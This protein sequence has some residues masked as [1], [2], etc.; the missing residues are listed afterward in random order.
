M[1]KG[2]NG[3]CAHRDLC[4]RESMR[5]RPLWL[6]LS[7]N[8]SDYLCFIMRNLFVIL[9]FV[10]L[11]ASCG[12]S[13]STDADTVNHGPGVPDP[14]AIVPAKAVDANA[15]DSVFANDF[16]QLISCGLLEDFDVLYLVPNLIP[17]VQ[18]DAMASG[19]DTI[20][21]QM[22]IDRVR[23][24]KLSGDYAVIKNRMHQVD[25]LRTL[26][27]NLVNWNADTAMLSKLGMTPGE[28][29]M[30]RKT[31]EE[32]LKKNPNL[33]WDALLDS[34]DARLQRTDP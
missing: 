1:H 24:F 25:S 15:P 32:L 12:D 27:V 4:V 23:R 29:Q 34:T 26:P 21:Y 20:T 11:L 6:I 19:K 18:A 10:L 13:A 22:L 5:E 8:L 33:R 3:T 7:S 9:S 17:E 28:M 16:G 14:C 30:L 2:H 31:A